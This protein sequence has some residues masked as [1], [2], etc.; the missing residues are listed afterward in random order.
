MQ[1][2]TWIG[3]DTSRA[4]AGLRA[5]VEAGA[6]C[7]TLVGPKSGERP[8]RFH[9]IDAVDPAEVAM[10]AE[11]LLP[12]GR[13][14]AGQW[15]VERRSAIDM[16]RLATSIEWWLVLEG[17]LAAQHDPGPAGPSGTPIAAVA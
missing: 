11:A 3:L 2:K 1:A 5:A 14:H 9:S 10:A 17:D 6:R 7:L 8:I 12:L 15:R 13:L 16:M 4:S